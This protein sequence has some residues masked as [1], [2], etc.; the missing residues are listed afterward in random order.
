MKTNISNLK[1]HILNILSEVFRSISVKFIALYDDALSIALTG[2]SIPS[3]RQTMFLVRNGSLKLFGRIL[4]QIFGPKYE[5][6]MSLQTFSMRY[7]NSTKIIFEK[8]SSSRSTN[9]LHPPL[10]ILRQLYGTVGSSHEILQKLQ[11]EL[12]NILQNFLDF[13]KSRFCSKIEI[14]V[15]YR[16]RGQ[17]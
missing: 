9:E 1:I 15:R 16:T 11:A 7:P 13:L 14:F 8:I 4:V 17:N 10:L 3:D 6:K 5:T 2:F 12:E